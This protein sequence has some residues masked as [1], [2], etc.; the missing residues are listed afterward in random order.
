MPGVFEERVV[1]DVCFSP[2]GIQL[3]KKIEEFW[4]G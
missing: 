2:V 1:F 4:R 3:G